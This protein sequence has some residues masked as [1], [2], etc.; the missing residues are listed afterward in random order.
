MSEKIPLLS[1]K[2]RS[3]CCLLSKCGVAKD[4]KYFAIKQGMKYHQYK[5]FE[6]ETQR[7]PTRTLLEWKLTEE[8]DLKVVQLCAMLKNIDR[9]DVVMKIEDTY[10]CSFTPKVTIGH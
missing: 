9:N 6:K 3:I 7:D 8:P 4:W 1:D 5:V 2:M 10:G